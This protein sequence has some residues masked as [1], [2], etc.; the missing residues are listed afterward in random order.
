MNA[1]HFVKQDLKQFMRNRWLLVFGL[2]FAL[3][4][5][6]L[7]VFGGSSHSS[8]EG[9]NRTTASLL[10]ANL[11]LIPLIVFI[12][13]GVTLSNDKEEGHFGLLL[14]YPVSYAALIVSKILSL[15][16]ALIVMLLLGYGIAALAGYFLAVPMAPGSFLTFFFLSWILVMC[17]A[18][19]SIMMGLYCSSKF[20]AMGASLLLWAVLVL[21]Y[22]FVVMALTD[23]VPAYMLT[24]FLTWIVA[25]NPVELMRVLAIVILDGGTTFGPSLYDFTLFVTEGFGI[26]IFVVGILL[27]ILIPSLI[28]YYLIRKGYGYAK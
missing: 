8:Y 16:L 17:L 3:V 15:I 21:F 24:M 13:G 2:L 28:S 25:M 5:T 20:Q 9:F 7:M 4:A 12:V 27:W 22:E 10:N 1:A 23:I 19:L 18:P 6:G 14:T 11:F 26:V